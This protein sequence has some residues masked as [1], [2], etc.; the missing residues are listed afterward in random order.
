MGKNIGQLSKRINAIA[1]HTTGIRKFKYDSRALA[2]SEADAECKKWGGNLLTIKSQVENEYFK[3]E[4][5]RRG[6][7]GAV[8]IGLS[9]QKEEG[10]FIWTSDEE[11]FYYNWD[12]GEPNGGRVEN[13]VE[14]FVGRDGKWNDSDAKRKRPFVC[15][16]RE[17]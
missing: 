12:Q 9:D 15:E 6:L 8:W 14:F 16:K 2:W 3:N 11:G 17:L 1:E 7:G 4:M 5:R 10:N 13:Y